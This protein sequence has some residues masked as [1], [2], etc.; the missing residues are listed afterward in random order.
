MSVTLDQLKEQCAVLTPQERADLAYFLLNSL[1]N[2]IEEDV[3]EAWQTEVRRRMAEIRA[4]QVTGKPAA[5]V[6]AEVREKYT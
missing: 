6:F 2:G 1:D 4:G 5:Q 3:A